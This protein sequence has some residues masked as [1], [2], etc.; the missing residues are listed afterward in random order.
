MRNLR[1]VV[2]L[3][4]WTRHHNPEVGGR[5]GGYQLCARCGR[6]RKSY[7]EGGNPAFKGPLLG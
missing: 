3:H 2:G 4:R 5:G 6:E 1:C 7:D